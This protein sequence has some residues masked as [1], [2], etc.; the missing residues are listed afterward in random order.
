MLNE[1]VFIFCNSLT[2]D[3][4]EEKINFFMTKANCS[5]SKEEVNTMLIRI[6]EDLVEG[7]KYEFIE[8]V[9]ETKEKLKE[10]MVFIP[11]KEEYLYHFYLISLSING[12]FKDMIATFEEIKPQEDLNLYSEKIKFNIGRAYA[13]VAKYDKA[14]D[15]LKK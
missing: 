14:I 7:K 13:K 6:V 4:I 2:K 5:Y 8:K 11:L 1:E 10:L 3:N 9:I 12:K 15:I